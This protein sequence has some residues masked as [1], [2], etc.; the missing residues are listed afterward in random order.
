MTRMPPHLSTGPAA[1]RCAATRTAGLLAAACVLLVMALGPDRL[2]WGQ[3]AP[4][5]TPAQVIPAGR[6][7]QNVAVITIHDVIDEWTLRS[8]QARIKRAVDDGADA[9]VFDIN[10]PGGELEAC[11]GICTAIKSSPVSNTVAWINPEAYSAGAII[12]LACREIVVNDPST[13][14]DALPITGDPLFGVRALPEAEREK[15]LGPLLAEVVDS[16]RRNGYDEM[17]V[18]GLVRRGVELWLVEHTTTGQRL[19]VT[20]DQ[21]RIAVGE[22]PVRGTPGVPS[23]TGTGRPLPP[24]APGPDPLG[25]EPVSESPTSYIPAAPGTSP[26]LASEVEASLDIRASR[27]LRPNLRAPGHAGQ[28]REVEYVSDG[29]GLILL[30]SDKMVQYDLAAAVVKSDED[31][32]RFFGATTVARLGE[33]WSIGLV[34]FLAHPITKAVLLV[35]F[36]LALFIEMTHPGVGLPGAIAVA[37]LAALVVPPLLVDLAAWWAVGAVVVGI[38]CLA[39]ELLLLPG[40]GVFGLVG[41]VLLFGGLIGV[42]V[43][44]PSGLFPSSARGRNDLA[45]SAVTVLVST[46]TAL[47]LMFFVA[48]H[49]PSL[50]VLGRFVLKNGL[51]DDDA[52]GRDELLLA[53]GPADA[54]ALVGQ[55]GRTITPLRP[56]G[57]VQVGERIIDVVSDMGFIDAGVEVRVVS[58]DTFRTVVERV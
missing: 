56:A 29:H 2:A 50:P 3:P 27:T 16:A 36:L 22:D 9:I 19:F 42:F 12:A 28:Y 35:V 24:P 8:V 31:L 10:T 1:V 52:A 40:F 39:V 4:S 15:I 48:R 6:A 45:F 32:R 14:G 46:V 44:G 38:V 33:S 57:R 13:F 51:D 11:L 26:E 30:K 55:V 20:E 43:G 25:T 37:A 7:A 23:V 18:Q 49:L 5:S 58:A 41:I 53:M 21:Y 47:I 34:R 54:A 17:L